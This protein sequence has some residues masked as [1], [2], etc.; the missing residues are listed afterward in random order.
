VQIP[1]PK[2]CGIFEQYVANRERTIQ[3]DNTNDDCDREVPQNR[4]E[5]ST[6]PAAESLFEKA[7]RAKSER[8]S[9]PV[10]RVVKAPSR[11]RPTTK[12]KGWFRCHPHVLIG[13]VDVFH[14]KE[15]G[16][17]AEDPVFILPDLAEELRME[18]TS[19]ENAIREMNCYLV[20]TK[21]GALY[22]FLAP[23]P[24][25][26]TGR[27]HP[28]TEQKIDAMEAAR[29]RWTRLEWSKA[30]L[31]FDV[32]TATGEIGEPSWPEDVSDGAIL[33]RTFGERNVIRE[34]DDPLLVKFRGEA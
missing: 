14:P 2:Y 12:V 9:L 10:T 34:R 17:F 11:I 13:P 31:Q 16:S 25:P 4:T 23:L 24:D 30:D 22:L 6:A 29:A 28:A 3:M 26:A 27:H 7:L 18:N 20:A 5:A 1:S 15:E 32:F 21:G 19:F 33:H 8:A